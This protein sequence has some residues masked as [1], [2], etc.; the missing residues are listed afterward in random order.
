MKQ[1]EMLET[2]D[3]LRCGSCKEVKHK[4]EFG[5]HKSRSTRRS[6][7]CRDCRKTYDKKYYALNSEKIQQSIKKYKRKNA[8]KLKAHSAVEKA[9]K[10]GELVRHPCEVCGA[11]KTEAH[12]ADYAK[13]LE[14]AWLCRVHHKDWHRKHGEALNA[15]TVRHW[16]PPQEATQ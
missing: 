11:K 15:C 14:V 1:L 9:I 8:F 7:Y 3:E 16:T 5:H 4:T 12:H 2:T 10:C 6:F 13:T